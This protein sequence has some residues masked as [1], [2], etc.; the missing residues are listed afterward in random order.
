MRLR[1]EKQLLFLSLLCI[2]SKVRETGHRVAVASSGKHPALPK[3][4]SGSGAGSSPSSRW[5]AGCL[6]A[7]SQR[8]SCAWERAR[9]NQWGLNAH[10]PNAAVVQAGMAAMCSARSPLPYGSVPAPA[11]SS[12]CAGRAASTSPRGTQP[13]AHPRMLTRS[14]WMPLTGFGLFYDLFFPSCFCVASLPVQSFERRGAGG[15]RSSKFFSSLLESQVRRCAGRDISAALCPFHCFPRHLRS[16]IGAT[17]SS[18]DELI[19]GSKGKWINGVGLA[20]LSKILFCNRNL[21]DE[22][23]SWLPGKL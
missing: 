18:N 17:L 13:S 16:L 1:L 8:Q 5:Q 11:G 4:G 14:C 15:A 23:C 19:T 10:G 3:G 20:N 12:L 22:K 6:A 21:K 9:I 2:L 7:A